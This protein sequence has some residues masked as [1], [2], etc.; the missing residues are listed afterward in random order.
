MRQNTPVSAV[1]MADQPKVDN[2]L[3]ISWCDS[4]WVPHLN[5]GNVLDY[6]S[7][8]SNPF[9]SR[10]CNNEFIKMQQNARIDAL[11]Q[12]QGTEYMLLHA[13]DPILYIIRKQQRYSPINATALASYHIIAGE[14]FQTPDIGTVL[15]SRLASAMSHINSSFTELS[16]YSQ[17][18]PSKGYWWRFHN[19]P[20]Q[21]LDQQNQP[22]KETKDKK[23]SAKE[24]AATVFQRRRVESLLADITTRFPYKPPPPTEGQDTAAVTGAPGTTAPLQSTSSTAANTSGGAAITAAVTSS[25]SSPPLNIKSEDIKQEDRPDSRMDIKVE[26]KQEIKTEVKTE[27]SSAQQH[28]QRTNKPPPEKRQRLN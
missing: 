3:H 21:P 10:D 13:Q 25:A 12:M 17:Y 28:F 27:G 15:N 8:R 20:P 9:Y 1:T 4:M 22:G 2:L 7:E 23:L 24:E 5:A 26:V 14:V 16:S 11:T 6:F 18:H 19:K